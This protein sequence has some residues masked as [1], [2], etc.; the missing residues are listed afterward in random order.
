MLT[1]EQSVLV[2]RLICLG[3]ALVAVFAQVRKLSK[4]GGAQRREATPWLCAHACEAEAHRDRAQGWYGESK[5]L[6]LPE[7]N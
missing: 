2:A 4:P 5:K 6:W 1:P 3:G 7:K